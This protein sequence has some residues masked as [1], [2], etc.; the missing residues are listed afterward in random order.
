MDADLLIG[1]IRTM[2]VI[3]G[4]LVAGYCLRKSGRA[5]AG[6]GSRVNRLT[7]TYIQPFVIG[8][9]LWS[10][11][12]PDWRTLALPLFGVAMIV[13]MWPLSAGIAR[14]LPLDRPARGTYIAS[15][16]FSNVGFTYGTFIAFVALGA[17]GAALG[18]LYCVSF[19]PAFFTLGFYI[20]RLHSPGK[21]R[22]ILAA[23]ID[24]VREG[25]T[26]NP[27]LGIAFGLAL[28]LLGVAPPGEAGFIIDITM[29]TTTAAFLFAIGL[30]LRLSA[31]K[32]YWREC[33]VM[34][35]TKFLVAPIVGLAIAAAFGYWQMPEHNLLKVAFIE[36]AAPTAIMAVLLADVFDLNRELAGALWL[37]TNISAVFLAPVLLL[38]ARML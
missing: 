6:L 10:M 12:R 35:A 5:G 37:T 7:L 33:L 15:S 28:N 21:Q 3:L 29:P 13:V 31:V 24:L 30:G 19:M 22:S 20:G 36:S 34:H 1:T 2:T 17:Q 38:I 25:H 27:I 16:I 23:L 11:Q 8:I 32:T 14:L 18:A 9:A 26:R 4:A